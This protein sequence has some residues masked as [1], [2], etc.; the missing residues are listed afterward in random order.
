MFGL[1]CGE[2]T[3]SALVILFGFQTELGLMMICKDM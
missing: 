2:M 3:M 1:F